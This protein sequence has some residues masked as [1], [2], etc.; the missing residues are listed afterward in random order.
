MEKRNNIKTSEEKLERFLDYRKGLSEEEKKMEAGLLLEEIK[1]INVNEAFT[2]VSSKINKHSNTWHTITVV[3]RIAASLTLPLFIVTLWL[4]FSH[5]KNKEQDNATYQEIQSPAGM[6][7]HVVLP[8]GTDLWLNSESKIRYSIPFTSE[9]RQLSLTGEA[10]L[11][12]IKNEKSPFIVNTESASVKVLGTQFNIKAYPEDQTLE[13]ALKEGSIEFTGKFNDGKKATTHMIPNDFLSMN[14]NTRQVKL[15]NKNI[16][17]YI[18][19]RKNIII[20]DDTPMPEVA[21]ILERWY[22]V[23]VVIAD[24]EIEK[25]RFTTT[26]ENESLFRVLELLEL[27]SPSIAIKYTPGKINQKSNIASSSTVTITKK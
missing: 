18:S 9:Y 10:Y 23:N 20:F 13:V 27:S 19:W 1:L 16:D 5:N 22:G 25:Y 2:Q 3:T 24:K 8:D 4:L 17:K 14:I 12:V 15:E 21:R 6:R 26:F 11:R 7:S